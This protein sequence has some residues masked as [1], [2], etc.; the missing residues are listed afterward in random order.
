MLENLKGGG[1][2]QALRHTQ[3][4][5]FAAGDLVSLIGN[6]VQRV[7]VGW[8]VWQLTESGTWLGILAVAELAPSILFAPL[9]GAFADKADRLKISIATLFGLMVQ[10]AAL[11]AL[12]LGGWIDIWSLLVLTCA[13]GCLN[14]WS[15]PAR[16][17]MVPSLVPKENLAP[18]IALNSV[19]FNTARFVGPAVA[20]VVIAQWGVGLAFLLNTASFMVFLLVLLRL[21]VPYAEV[22][23]RK[24]QSLF[25]Q[26]SEGYSYVVGHPGIGPLM[27]LLLFSAILVRPVSDLLPGFAGAVFDAGPTGLAWLT[28]AMGLGS[29]IGAFT[30]AQRGHMV[31]LTRLAV[32]HIMLS[33]GALIVFSFAPVFWIAVP[34]IAVASYSITITGISCQSLVQNSV[35]GELR[36]RVISIYAVIFRA[37]PAVGALA[38]GALSEVFGWHWPM[39]T[40]AALCLFVWL[41]GRKRQSAMSAALEV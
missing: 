1:I 22:L 25:D 5:R 33:G 19:L 29:T 27:L 15:H 18:A 30:I 3:F 4:R 8:L 35:K 21:Q 11:T 2:A 34:V 31:G 20:G 24:R 16:Q 10:A 39:A 14:A 40:S 28:S 9:G 32:N 38:L 17:A 13:R 7:A 41:W 23:K 6:W 36:G 26:L 37:A 12:T